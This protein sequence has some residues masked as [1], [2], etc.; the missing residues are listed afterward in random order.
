MLPF[1]FY[2]PVKIYFGNGSCTEI[3]RYL[4]GKYKKVLLVYAKGPFRENGLYAE[5]KTQFE[6]TGS[7]VYKMSDIDS[8]PKMYSVY[9][10]ISIARDNQ[11]DCIADLGGGSAIMD[12]TKLMAMSAKTDIDPCEYVWGNR[13]KVAGSID[14]VMIPT[15]AATGTEL[16]NKTFNTLKN[17][18][19]I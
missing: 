11:I 1:Q 6:K 10:G 12:C 3:G 4:K 8:N 17:K 14:V 15:I 16:N 7:I 2:N 18:R 13:S 19:R 5:V 9:E